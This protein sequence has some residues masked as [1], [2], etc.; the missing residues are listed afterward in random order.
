MQCIICVTLS[1][2]K[3]ENEVIYCYEKKEIR[4]L[5]LGI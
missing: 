3:L 2:C 4:Q 1:A 5:C